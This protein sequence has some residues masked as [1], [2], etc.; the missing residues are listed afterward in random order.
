MKRKIIWEEFSK[1]AAEQIRKGKSLTGEDGIFTPLIKEVLEAAL[2]GE[3][4]EHLK[5]TR[6]PEKNRR[7]GRTQ[8]NL[9]SSLG[10]FEIFTPRDRNGTYTPQIIEKRKTFLPDDIEKKILGLYGLGMSYRDIQSHLNEMYGL[11]VSDGTINSITDRIIPTIREWQGRPLERI[12]AVIW[13][14]AIYFKVREEGRVITKAVYSILG[15]NMKGKK[16]ILGLY[17]GE[18]ESA[19]FWLQVLTD[20]KKR[21]IEDILISCIDN[22]KGFSEA[23]ENI[24]PKTEV[25]LC[26]VHQIRNSIKY[27][28]KKHIKDFLNDLKEVYKASSIEIASYKLDVLETKWNENYKVVINSWRN[29]WERLTQYFKYPTEIRKLIYTT[30]AIEGYHRMVRKVTKSKGAFTSDMAI[31]KLVYLVTV[32]INNKWNDFTIQHWNAIINQLFIFFADRIKKTD[33]V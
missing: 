26:V 18:H 8:K 17:L 7:N 4:D 10:G 5:D 30:N 1:K 2:E 33:T 3:M 15:L 16:E 12:Y 25:Q 11:S 20:L 32:Q 31:L 27:I 9:K 23:I 28:S 13:M 29:N 21:G 19:T 14:D 24:F 22:L 6:D